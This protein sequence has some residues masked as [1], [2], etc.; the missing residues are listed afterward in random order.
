MHLFSIPNK[1]LTFL[2][3]TNLTANYLIFLTYANVVM[4]TFE[5]DNNK[6]YIASEDLIVFETVLVS[7]QLTSHAWQES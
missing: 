7:E 3:R 5:T 4:L 1:A 6:K 2:Q